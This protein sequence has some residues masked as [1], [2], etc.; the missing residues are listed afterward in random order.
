MP[1]KLVKT[2]K[3][4]WW[5]RGESDYSAVLITRKLLILQNGRNGKTGTS[6]RV[7]HTFGHTFARDG[8]VALKGKGRVEISTPNHV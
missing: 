3:S 1:A 6:V 2:K 4:N 5:R 8:E 7:G